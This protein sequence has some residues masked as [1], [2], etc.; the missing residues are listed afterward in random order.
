MATP[1]PPSRGAQLGYPGEAIVPSPAGG[2]L[3]YH[4]GCKR[5]LLYW[6]FS[7]SGVFGT[8]EGAAT[9]SIIQVTWSLFKAAPPFAAAEGVILSGS[10]GEGGVGWG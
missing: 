3:V 9:V 6:G 7:L 8:I 2:L 1:E 10:N 5:A 4:K